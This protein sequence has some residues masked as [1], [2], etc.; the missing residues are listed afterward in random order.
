MEAEEGK[1]NEQEYETGLIPPDR[2]PT[3]NRTSTTTTHKTATPTDNTL[4]PIVVIATA[5][6]R[7]DT[8]W[9]NRLTSGWDCRTSKG[10]EKEG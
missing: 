1:E 4:P 3:W 8:N 6:G 10:E 9:Q 2:T 5:T 7:T